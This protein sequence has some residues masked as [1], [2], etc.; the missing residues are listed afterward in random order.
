VRIPERDRLTIANVDRRDSSTV[1]ENAGVAP[2]DGDPT[3]PGEAQHQIGLRI[4]RGRGGEAQP[5]QWDVA[6]VSVGHDHVATRGKDVSRRT[7]ENGER[8]GW[9]G[10]RH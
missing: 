10:G 6:P 9:E 8:E 1:D 5:V 2:I 7:D 3:R 4:R